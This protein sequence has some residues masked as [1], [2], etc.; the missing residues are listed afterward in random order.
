MGLSCFV[1]IKFTGLLATRARS[2][3]SAVLF[4]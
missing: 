4:V 1:I 2:L 3:F